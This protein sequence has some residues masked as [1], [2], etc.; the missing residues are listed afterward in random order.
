MK[1]D[2]HSNK[3]VS[4]WRDLDL[5]DRCHALSLGEKHIMSVLLLLSREYGYCF[6]GD[7]YF[8]QKWGVATTTVSDHFKKLEKAGFIRRERREGQRRI[9][10]EFATL[11]DLKDEHSSKSKAS[12]PA[13]HRDFFYYFKG[14]RKWRSS[15]ELDKALEDF[16]E[17]R[18]LNKK[19]VT[20][21]KVKGLAQT[22]I[23]KSVGDIEEAIRIVLRA[24]TT[25]E[26]SF[27]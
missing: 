2:A 18:R 22:L 25:T 7:K 3:D 16:L 23:E 26:D 6:A 20:R 27:G 24:D 5:I 17:A 12:F 9:T 14:N 19:L 21:G 15:R 4:L 13:T 1:N 11:H 8:A 10:I